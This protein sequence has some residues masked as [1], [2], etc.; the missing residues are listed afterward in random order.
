VST[1]ARYISPVRVFTLACALVL[2]WGYH[3]PLNQF[4]T[5]QRGLGY[6]LGI[7][8]GSMM[9]LVVI[10]PAR[11]RLQALGFIGSVPAWFRAHMLLGVIGPILV[12]FHSN[13]SLGATNSN[14]ALYCMLLVSGSGIVGRYFYSRVY[15]RLLGRQATVGEVQAV[16]NQLRS[17]GSVVAILPDVLS[18]I[19][20]EEQWLLA[21]AHG[22]FTRLFHPFTIGVRAAMARAH[23]RKFI[24][25]SVASAASR[26]HPI[27]MQAERLTQTAYGY[28]CRRLDGQRRLAEYK[29]YAGLFSYWHVLHVPLFI[30]LII[31]ATVHIVSANIY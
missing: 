4:I 25:Q 13:F 21:P 29:L 14:V 15:D 30:L 8:G 2:L 26:S 24:M 10:Y 3:A 17:Q 7:I 9:L 12:L 18:A 16:A 19:E 6:A 11:K 28:A 27:A 31:A 1:L 23:L 5:P 22:P 20:R